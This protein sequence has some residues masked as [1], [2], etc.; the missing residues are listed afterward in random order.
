[1]KTYY[2]LDHNYI[3]EPLIYGDISLF[4]VG[5]AFLT[6]DGASDEHLQLDLYELTI[7]TDGKGTIGTG[8]E[9]VPVSAGD[10]FLSF[11][12][13]IHSIASDEKTPLKYDFISFSI[14]SEPYKSALDSLHL[15][16]MNSSERLFTDERIKNTV[17]HIIRELGDR[18]S[19]YHSDIVHSLLMQVLIYTLRS[20]EKRRASSPY[21]NTDSRDI[22][23]YQLMSYIDTHVFS[24][25]HLSEL[26]EIMNY[27]Y[28]YL[29]DLFKSTTGAT[30]SEYY[31]NARLRAAKL[32]I[33]EGK[34]KVSEIAELLNY[35]SIYVFSRAYKK[36]YGVSPTD[37]QE[38]K[39]E[40]TE[41]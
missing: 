16:F 22:L 20:F 10:I 26:G 11:P 14:S 35:S 31:R 39:D 29:S 12:A 33:A 25:A 40:G 19:E 30:L 28:S 23:C 4:Q 13:D 1:M 2:H 34:L 21:L 5:R 27:N 24:L 6:E 41:K 9:Q 18:D 3:K 38:K 15:E 37:T 7:V 8:G 32:L 17:S 36:K